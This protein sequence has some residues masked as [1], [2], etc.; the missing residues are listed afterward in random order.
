LFAEE[1]MMT[2]AFQYLRSTAQRSLRPLAAAGRCVRP[3]A[4]AGGWLRPVL[5]AAGCAAVG[6]SGCSRQEAQ[7]SHRANFADLMPEA[8]QYVDEALDKHFGQPTRMVVWEKLPLKLHSAVGAVGSKPTAESIGINYTQLNLPVDPGLEVRFL[9]GKL[10]DNPPADGVWVKNVDDAQRVM[11]EAA[12]PTVAAEGD[13]VAINPGGVLKLGRH[14]FAEHCLHCH[15]ASGDG[16]GPT[17]KYLNPLPRDYRRGIFKFTTTTATN[18]ARRDDLYRIVEEGI[19]GTYM[20]SFKL[21]T[22]AE[23]MALVEYVLWLANRGELEYQLVGQLK[24]EYSNEAVKD[25]VAGGETQQSILKEFTDAVNGT[26]MSETFDGIV[27]AITGRWIA[28]QEESA[29]IVPGSKR[30]ESSPESIARGRALYLSKDLNCTAC[31]GESGLGDGP[32]TYSITKDSQGK[33]NPLPGL[34][35]EWGHQIRP[36]NLTQ[37][38]YRGGRRPI[39]LFD[40]LHG[41]I[42]GTPMPSFGGKKTDAELWD[43]V[44]YILSVPYEHR[45]PGDGAKEARPAA[46]PAKVATN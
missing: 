32:Q 8:Q 12:I 17:A 38:I 27:D 2:S 24:N 28:A 3:L 15:G 25:R 6:L 11:F 34:Y 26:D 42:K 20:P 45:E 40:R 35:D 29:I 22:K 41:G 1:I 23:N 30:V 31:H 33:D 13:R 39:D 5:A 18:R 9:S 46:E 21:L 16:D 44:N 10:A 36:R 37:G 43:V 14:L 4:A 7:F 19:P